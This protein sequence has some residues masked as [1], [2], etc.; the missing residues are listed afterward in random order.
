MGEDWKAIGE[1]SDSADVNFMCRCH[2]FVTR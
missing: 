1:L 2:F